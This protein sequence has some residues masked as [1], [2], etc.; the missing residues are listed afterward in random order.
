[1]E[2]QVLSQ[3]GAE[4]NGHAHHSQFTPPKNLDLGHRKK[5]ATT[6]TLLT[7]NARTEILT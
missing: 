5:N 4:L 6:Q 2:T 7:H 1:M 3:F